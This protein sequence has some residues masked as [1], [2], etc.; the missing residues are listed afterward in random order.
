MM[1]EQP[2]VALALAEEP[3]FGL[4]LAELWFGFL[5]FLLGM[6]LFLD[7]FD[8]GAGVLFATRDDEADR[9]QIL[10]AI[11][12]FW[13][14]NEVWLVVFGGTLFAAFPA[15]YANLFSRQYLLV[16][17]IL[18]ALIL[19]GL[20]PEMYEQRDDERWHRL[21]GSAF[22]VGSSSSP[23]FLG[24]LVANWLLG[25]T[26]ILTGPG[27]VVGL[28]L[29]ALTVVDGA[30]FLGLKVRGDLR[31]DLPAHGTRA[32]AGYLLSLLG[33]LGYLALTRPGLRPMLGSPTGLALVLVTGVLTAVYVLALRRTRYD[34]ALGATAGL[35]FTLV[36]FVG[37]LMY[38]YVDPAVELTVREAIVSTLSL[39]LITVGAAFLIPL[40]LLY[41]AVLYAAFSGPIG[42]DETY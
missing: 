35:V 28:A 30:A 38:P 11:G 9:E 23:F 15:A 32:A 36:A 7:G 41:F 21:W 34:V 37:A 14:G 6:F 16:F 2:T 8:F 5:F 42:A 24:L 26:A 39:N 18:A 10:A 19:R 33:A 27:V 4:P 3:L 12:P 31:E 20:A 22:V 1:T 40:V 25:S 13:D 17:A 29:V